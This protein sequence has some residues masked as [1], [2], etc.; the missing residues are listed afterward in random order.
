[1]EANAVNRR[2][3][4]GL[5]FL[6]VFLLSHGVAHSVPMGQSDLEPSDA[7]A[8]LMFADING[9]Q[10]ITGLDFIRFRACYIQGGPDCGT[11]DFD[12]NQVIDIVD[13]QFFASA[14]V[15]NTT[16]SQLVSPEPG[17]LLLVAAGCLLL[18]TQSRRRGR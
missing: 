14:Y 10:V 12:G 8:D 5:L 3:S 11:V 13:F 15:G 16:P 9:D 2:A 7:S 18:A 6:F 17:T 4:L 1:M